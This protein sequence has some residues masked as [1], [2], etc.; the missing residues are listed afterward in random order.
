MDYEGQRL[1]ELLFQWIICS[2]GAVGWVI[3]YINQN[4]YHTFYV[5]LVGVIISVIVSQS[6]G[7]RL[8][9]YRIHFVDDAHFLSILISPGRFAFRI[10]PSSTDTQS[11]GLNLCQIEG[12]SSKG[13][14]ELRCEY[15]SVEP[16][17][18]P[19]S[20]YLLLQYPL[21]GL[22]SIC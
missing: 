14:T 18:G 22:E 2:L 1:A 11:N 21:A 9:N 7:P 4:F 17:L 20:C 12:S 3:G 5:W 16:L 19:S 15:R 13:A 6:C 8:G 10:G